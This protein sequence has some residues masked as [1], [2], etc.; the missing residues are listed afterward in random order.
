[1]TNGKNIKGEGENVIV[2]K[3]DRLM[4]LRRAEFF[5][6]FSSISVER[7]LDE[8]RSSTV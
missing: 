7:I 2:G 6:A 8:M 5:R 3:F 4:N 1:M